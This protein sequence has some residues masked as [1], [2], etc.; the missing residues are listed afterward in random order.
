MT[1]EKNEQNKTDT[2]MEEKKNAEAENNKE[3][4][5]NQ[6]EKEIEKKVKRSKQ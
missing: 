4:Y 3:S 2:E 1:D 6:R 5:P